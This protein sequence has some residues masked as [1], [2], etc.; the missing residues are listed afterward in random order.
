[1]GTKVIKASSAYGTIVRELEQQMTETYKPILEQEARAIL[2]RLYGQVLNGWEG[3][4]D[5]F[6]GT[7]QLHPAPNLDT[8]LKIETEFFIRRGVLFFRV[9]SVVLDG[10]GG[11]F[12]TF[13]WAD[14]GTKDKHWSYPYRSRVFERRGHSTS[15]GSLRHT[16]AGGYGVYA[17]IAPG[18]VRK[19]IP[20]REF[21]QVIGDTFGK[22][23]LA[24]GGINGWTMTRLDRKSPLG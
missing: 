15:P 4:T 21:T 22:E 17:S 6:G 12:R 3:R 5:Y 19:G 20:A 23:A 10:D 18:Q 2:K 1:M 9:S 13:Y 24:L 11:P 16:A 8:H 14:F 7:S